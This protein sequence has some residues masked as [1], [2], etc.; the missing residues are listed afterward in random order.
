[1]RQN[2]TPFGNSTTGKA[3]QSTRGVVVTNQYKRDVL[4]NVFEK[5]EANICSQPDELNDIEK[6]MINMNPM[7]CNDDILLGSFGDHLFSS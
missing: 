3:N 4:D 5:V 6:Q 7:A 2:L 1:M